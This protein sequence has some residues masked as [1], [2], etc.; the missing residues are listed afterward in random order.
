MKRPIITLTTDWG[1]Q[2][3]FAGMVK[4]RLYSLIEDVEVVDV[5]HSVEPFKVAEA[6]FV[7]RNACLAFPAG[8][9]HIV[10][11]ASD[12]TQENAFVVVKARGQYFICCDNGLPTMA[13]G[14]EVEEAVSIPLQEMRIYNFAAYSLFAPT[15]AKLAGGTPMSDLGPRV[16]QLRQRMLP[17]W[18]SQGDEY[19]IP[20]QYIDSYGNAYLGMSYREFMDLSQGRPFMMQVREYRIT[21]IRSSYYQKPTQPTHRA[22]RAGGIELC[23]TV[24][25]TGMLEIAISNSNFAQYIGMQ[26]GE[27]VLLQFITR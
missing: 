15:A 20:I 18:V 8:T 7:V 10:D 3:F 11:V 5:A 26:L 21:E 27:M 4:G 9:I 1:N 14:H 2:S 19:R 16:E 23:L 12:P 22:A 6:T 13:F 25:A 24:S 17:S